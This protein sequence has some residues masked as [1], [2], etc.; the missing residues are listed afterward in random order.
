[1]SPVILTTPD[2]E[3]ELT[4]AT[5]GRTQVTLKPRDPNLYIPRRSCQTSHPG[6]VEF[7]LRGVCSFAWVCDAIARHEESDEVF[8]VLKRQLF[9]YFEAKAF[10][11]ARMLD[12]GC[13]T[14]ASTFAM[15]NMLPDT[16]IVGLEL[17]PLRVQVCQQIAARRETRNARFFVS[18]SGD[19]VPADIGE[20]QFIMFSAVYEHLLPHERRKLMPQLWAMLKPG[21]VLFINQTPHRWAPFEHHSTELW[22]T[23]YFPDRLA[24]L[25]ARFCS[26]ANPITNRSKDWN[27]HLRGG[28]RGATE[29]KIIADLTAGTAARALVIQPTAGGF[30]DRA[31]YWLAGTSRKFRPLKH[32]IAVVFRICDRLWDT[33]PALNV[34]VAMQKVTLDTLK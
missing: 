4:A 31:D 29:R 13:G 16:E 32:C 20:F 6:E 18:P 19:T 1:M 9:G 3:I 33:I 34:D 11:S 7:F 24:H 14:G 15:A 22:G 2:G 21:G 26:T 12:F 10:K 25:Y 28:I 8:D 17:D 5:N 23:N 27:D 30:R